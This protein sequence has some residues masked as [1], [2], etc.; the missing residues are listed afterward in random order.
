[1]M[2][3]L[4]LIGCLLALSA[5][6]AD[7]LEFTNGTKVTG[8]LIT[9]ENAKKQLTFEFQ[10]N[11]QQLKRTFAYAQ[12]HALTWKGKR[13][14]LT[15]KAG[16]GAK[17]TR[18]KAEVEALIAQAGRT[19]P[20]WLNG[21]RLN[22][23][24]SLDLNW[25]QP[26]PKGW[27]SSKNVG[28]FLW[29]IIN[30]NTSRWREGIRFMNFMMDRHKD[31]GRVRTRATKAL[32]NMYFIYLQDYARAAYWWR[33]A[34]AG[35]GE[36]HNTVLAECY[37]RLGNKDMAMDQLKGAPLRPALIKLYGTMGET[38]TAIRLAQRFGGNQALH[39]NLL[40]GDAC[41]LAGRTQGAIAFYRT[42][43]AGKDN[44]GHAKTAKGPRAGKHRRAAARAEGGG[45]PRGRR[46]VPRP[47]HRLRGVAGGD[48]DGERQAHHGREGDAPSR[49]AVLQFHRGHHET[50]FGQAIG[51]GHRRDQPRD[52]HLAGDCQRRRQGAGQGREIKWR[53][54]RESKPSPW[55]SAAGCWA[56]RYC[57]PKRV[58][59]GLP[60][61]RCSWPPG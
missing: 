50:D 57:F 39:A 43:L 11:G 44:K 8:K 18:T 2:R 60:W 56:R 24:K 19:S 3:W 35:K 34:G 38:D 28:Q 25:P 5:Q 4:M 31:N 20:P 7:Q 49:E 52:H 12:V 42:V 36:H 29:D 53:N 15:A 45:E 23:P 54:A 17:A 33:R 10:F 13:Y 16:G 41:R 37:F 26:A 48:R 6:A 21:T 9:F 1:M 14:V 55:A 51:E 30:P 59:H 32:A 47:N 58:G 61:A 22:Y 46:Y 27:N 40:A